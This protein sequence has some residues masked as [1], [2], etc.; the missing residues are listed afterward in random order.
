MNRFKTS[1]YKNCIPKIPK[2]EGWITDIGGVS[3]STSGNNIRCGHRRIVYSTDS[4]G[5]LGATSLQVGQG[6]K[7]TISRLHCHS[8]VVTDFAFS[9]FDDDLLATGSADQSVKLW[10]VSE[11]GDVGDS[12]ATLTVKGGHVK[13]LQFHP[14]ADALLVSAAGKSVQVW[15]LSR[16]SALAALDDHGDQ[17]QSICWSQDGVLIGTTSKDKRL[18][19]FDVRKSTKAIQDA[20][21]HNN[22]KDSRVVW[23]NSNNHLL[24]SGFNQVRERELL[25]WD[26]RSFSRPVSSFSLDASSGLLIPLYDVDTSLL[27]LAAQ[28]EGTVYCMEVG[29]EPHSL[30]QLSQCVTEQQS[31]GLALAPKLCLDVMGS[32]VLR[33]LQLTDRFIIP[34]SFTVPR[35]QT[36]AEFPSDLFPDTAGCTAALSSQSWWTGENKQ[37]GKVSLNPA[38]R[39]PPTCLLSKEK[40][41]NHPELSIASPEPSDG[42]VLTSPS[43]SVTSPSSGIVSSASQRSLQSILGPSSR[44]RHTQGVVLH[45][46]HHIT[47]LKGVSQST[48]GESDGFCV[49]HQRLAVPLAVAGGQVAVLELSQ[50]GRLSDTLPTVQNSVPV[51]DLT[52]DPFNHHRLVTGG[53]DG[54]IRVWEIPPHGLKEVLTEPQNTLAVHNE[55]IYTVRFHPCAS[56]ILASSSYDL[57]LRIWNL[58]TGKNILTLQGHDDQ[59]FSLAWSPDG[60]HLATCCKDQRIRIYEPRVSTEAQQEGVGPEGPRGARVLWVCDGKY[61]LVSGFDSRSERQLT[62]HSAQDLSQGPIATI[63]IDVSPATLIPYY[64]PDTG[65]LLLTG[66]GDTRVFL[67]EVVPESP[68]FLECNTFIPSDPHKGFQY[69]RKADCSVPDVEILRALRLCYSSVEPVA[70]RVPRVKKEFFQDDVFPPSRVTWQPALTAEEWLSGKDKQQPSISLCPQGMIPVSQA[71]KEAPSKKFVPAAVYLQEKTDEQKKEELL[72]AMVAKLG[73]RD[74]PLPQDA[75][76]GVDEDEWAKYL[77]QI[78]VMG[79]QVVGRAFT[80]ALRQEFAASR[81]AA[82]ARGG[83]AGKESAAASS[84]SGISLQEAQQILNVSKLEPDEIQTKF[85]HLFKVNDKAAG[86]SFYLQSKVVRAKER[87]DQELQIQNDTTR[88]GEESKTT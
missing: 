43:S 69:L 49:N 55:R 78:L 51:T 67:Y 22:N 76:E 64:D 11:T 26:L 58:K 19:I 45:R 24:T 54:R 80:R 56:D 42:S 33:L 4:P 71:P 84:L 30:A 16:D 8:D 82:E 48:P 63:S 53:E 23:T 6:E 7:R 57:T 28:G 68:Y 40:V 32:E 50:A 52:W 21:G 66:K 10:R 34:I 59:I 18:R 60:K 72:S 46:D 5:V 87:L 73:N 31:R 15:D 47:N 70:F 13:A 75:F 35:K 81:A 83:R 14:S 44:L 77:A 74:D 86:G 85:D 1:K 20:Q 3:A 12:A 38:R 79:A 88:S 27:I 61:L 17:V 25:L 9:P 2:K 65:L 62:L 39:S 41:T 37:V 36:G 29:T